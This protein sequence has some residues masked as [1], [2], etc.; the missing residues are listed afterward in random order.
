MPTGIHREKTAVYGEY[1]MGGKVFKVCR[2]FTE[3]SV[4]GGVVSEVYVQ[5]SQKSNNEKDMNPFTPSNEFVK[6]LYLYKYGF[7]IK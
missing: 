7:G 4:G 1:L 6:L 5:Q 3:K 2:V